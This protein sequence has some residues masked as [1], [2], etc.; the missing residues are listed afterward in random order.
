MITITE[1]GMEFGPY[2]DED[3]FQ[4]EKSKLLNQCNGIKTVEFVYRRKKNILW[5]VEA[6]SSAPIN[7][8]DNLTGYEEFVSDIA[9]KIVDSFNLYMAGVL[10]RKAGHEAISIQMKKLDYS[11]VIFRFFLI[12]N[13]NKVEEKMPVMDISWAEGLKMDLEKRVKNFQTVWKGEIYVMDSIEAKASGM[14]A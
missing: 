3:I 12:I 6:K 1:S 5:F 8:P 13:F 11:K 14:I 4:I 2:Q 9:K 10:E 7:R